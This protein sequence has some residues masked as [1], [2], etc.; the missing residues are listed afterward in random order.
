ML[1]KQ[2]NVCEYIVKSRQM[3]WYEYFFWELD[4]FCNIIE[5]VGTWLMALQVFFIGV[6]VYVVRCLQAHQSINKIKN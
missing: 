2:L 6:F 4:E 5:T 1:K 3:L